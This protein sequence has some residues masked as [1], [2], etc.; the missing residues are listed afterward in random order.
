MRENKLNVFLSEYTDFDKS[1]CF[2]FKNIWNP[3]SGK[4]KDIHDPYGPLCFIPDDLIYYFYSHRLDILWNN[5]EDT[6]EGYYKDGV[7]AGKNILVP[8]R[9]KCINKNVIYLLKKLKF[10]YN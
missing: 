2:M 8:S 7:S 1:N 4:R 3:Y 10:K 5:P 9:G 6:V